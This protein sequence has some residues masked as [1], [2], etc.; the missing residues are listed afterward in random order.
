MEQFAKSFM[1]CKSFK[2]RLQNVNESLD[3]LS[4]QYSNLYIMLFKEMK[5]RELEY[6]DSF[7]IIQWLDTKKSNS[8]FKLH[9]ALIL[10]K[11]HNMI[12]KDNYILN[13]RHLLQQTIENGS[14]IEAAV[15]I[16]NLIEK[17]SHLSTIYE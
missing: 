4:S 6:N 10:V 7:K 11:S 3:H 17:S 15:K 2:D 8:Y 16:C 1:Q 12:A 9:E 5:K 13:L 14:D